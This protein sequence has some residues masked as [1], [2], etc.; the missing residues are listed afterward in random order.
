MQQSLTRREVLRRSLEWSAAAGLAATLPRF[1]AGAENSKK[2]LVTSREVMFAHVPEPICWNAMKQVGIDG[3][4]VTINDKLEIPGLRHP[5]KKYSIAD[6]AGIKMLQDDVQSAGLRITALAMSNH[7]DERA[8]FEVEWGQKVAEAAKAMGVSAVRIDVVARKLTGDA[9]L[10]FATDVLKRLIAA[11]ATTGVR[12]GIENH[13]KTT[14]DPQFLSPLLAGVGSD[15]LG[16]TLDTGN[17]YWFGHPLSKVYEFVE[18][19]A[20]RVFHTHCKSI[21]YP[22]EERETQRAMGWRYAELNCPITDGDIDYGRVVGILKKVG[23]ANDMCIENESLR[24]FKPEEVSDVLKK[25]VQL[26]R[27]VC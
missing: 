19:F 17:F 5:E 13:G 9:F 21:R 26:L 4:E 11:T 16:L 12:F 1:A 25:E 10:P 7:F 23:Y 24:K 6:A 20:S 2:L 22:A 18:Q 8:D 27:N 14:N 3:I 15:R